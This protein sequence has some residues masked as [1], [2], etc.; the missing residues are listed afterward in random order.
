MCG[1]M[2]DRTKYILI[3]FVIGII[4]GMILFYVLMSSR[5]IQPFLFGGTR[6]FNRTL[7]RP[8]TI[9]RA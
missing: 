2:G 5:I 6:A 4:I 9:P 8:S 7:E 3:G 1:A